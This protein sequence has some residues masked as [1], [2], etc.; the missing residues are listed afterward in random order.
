VA[1]EDGSAGVS[2]I[3][4]TASF[5]RGANWTA[6]ILVNDNAALVDELQPN[7]T[8][9]AASGK[10]AVGFYDRRLPCETGNAAGSQYD[11]AAAGASNYCINTAVQF[12]DASLHPLGQN[13]RASAHTW[14]PQ[15]NAPHPGS[16]SGGTTFIGDY[17]G[18][19]STGTAMVTTSVS[20]Y[21]YAGE[22]PS[23]DQQQIVA[24]VPIP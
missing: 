24:R 6:P 12:Y 18:I 10:V 17:F 23:H 13:V 2:N 22:N 14:D 20:T 11:P 7:L 3:W 21:D 9:D 4:L 5:D 1:W 16:I 19:E 8:V 15:L